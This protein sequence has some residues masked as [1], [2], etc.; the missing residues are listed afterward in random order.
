MTTSLTQSNDYG[1]GVTIAWRR[2]E[3]ERAIIVALLRNRRQGMAAA[4][5][6]G[7]TRDDFDQPDLRVIFVA[8][9]HSRWLP[10]LETLRSAKRMLSYTHYWDDD[11]PRGSRGMHWSSATL[12]E[13]A[14]ATST[15]VD[16]AADALP[17]MLA[18]LKV[19]DA[20]STKKGVAA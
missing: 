10:L 13:A 18:E 14:G 5:A 4:Q 9:Q 1:Q 3:L 15:D 2:A 17:E 19:I 6:A 8:V 7:I 16:E 12:A 20:A 11:V